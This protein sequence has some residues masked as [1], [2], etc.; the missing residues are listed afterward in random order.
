MVIDDKS[1]KEQTQT[2][3]DEA[4]AELSDINKQITEWNIKARILE[5]EVNA[6]EAALQ[7]YLKRKGDITI[8]VTDWK[9]LLKKGE[10]HKERIKLIAEN[11]GGKIKVSQVTDILFSNGFINT[12]KRATA[13]SIVQLSLADLIKKGEVEKIGK[14]EYRLVGSQQVLIN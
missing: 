1:Y 13:Y 12:K 2:L 10:T 9:V 5:Q 3:L 14:G 4:K 11:K 6:Y 7:A 8:E